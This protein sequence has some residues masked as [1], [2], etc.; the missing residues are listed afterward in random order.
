MNMKRPGFIKRENLATML[1]FGVVGAGVGLLVGSIV[2]AKL[3]AKQDEWEEVEEH[4]PYQDDILV[5]GKRRIYHHNTEG[6]TVEVLEEEYEQGKA[7]KKITQKEGIKNQ[8]EV[9]MVKRNKKETAVSEEETARF[10]Y[11][12]AQ[13]PIT[14]IQRQLWGSGVLP[15][16]D[17]VNALEEEYGHPDGD[18]DSPEHGADIYYDYGKPDLMEI[19]PSDPSG[20]EDATARF[21]RTN[22]KLDIPE[23]ATV[24]KAV[25]HEEE[26]ALFRVMNDGTQ[27][28]YKNPSEVIGEG[29]L[30]EVYDQLLFEEGVN[31]VYVIDNQSGRT[32]AITNSQPEKKYT[33]MDEATFERIKRTYPDED[34]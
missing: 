21:I 30:D 13:Y 5:S 31:T 10:E 33:D 22:D 3:A 4:H 9:E 6:D 28:P 2:A 26:D 34:E 25:Y 19:Q 12:S 14:P 7:K 16:E 11:L 8:R 24:I 17:L 18:L 29:M 23:S 15:L 20:E 1:A 27:I 32:I